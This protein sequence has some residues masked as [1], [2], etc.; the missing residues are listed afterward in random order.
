MLTL[1]GHIPNASGTY[2]V[3]YAVNVTTYLSDMRL[4][5]NCINH[6]ELATNYSSLVLHLRNHGGTSDLVS[7]DLLSS[8]T[9]S[10]SLASAGTYRFD[11]YIEY[12]PKTASTNTILLDVY[13]IQ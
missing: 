2:T 5:I 11:Y 6:V 3:Q 10:Y 7:L 9:L 1:L 13:V 8:D 4:Q 12:T